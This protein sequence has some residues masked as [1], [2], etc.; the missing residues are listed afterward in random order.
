[1]KGVSREVT[2]FMKLRP[3]LGTPSSLGSLGSLGLRTLEI[4]A[5]LWDR[6][7]ASGKHIKNLFGFD[8]FKN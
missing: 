1:M 3:K 7:T 6:T 8:C 4:F 5:T 2:R